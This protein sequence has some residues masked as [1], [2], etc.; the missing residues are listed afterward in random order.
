MNP[1][2]QHSLRFISVS[3]WVGM[4]STYIYMLLSF[5]LN[6]ARISKR[7][8]FSATNLQKRRIPRYLSLACVCLSQMAVNPRMKRS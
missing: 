2:K 3:A 6:V 4:T 7:P 8:T 5:V 1:E